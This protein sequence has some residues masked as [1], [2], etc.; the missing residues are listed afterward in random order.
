MLDAIPLSEA[1]LCVSCNVITVAKNGHCPVC[2]G[3]GDGLLRLDKALNRET[4]RIIIK[5]DGK[6]VWLQRGSETML[7]A[8]ARTDLRLGCDIEL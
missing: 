7:L 6:R 8:E 3:C 1:V 2:D 5:S 4:E